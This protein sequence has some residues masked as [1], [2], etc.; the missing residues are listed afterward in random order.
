MAIE[1]TKPQRRI[2][3]AIRDAIAARGYPPTIREIATSLGRSGAGG[4]PA[5]LVVLERKGWIKRARC[6]SRA[7]ELVYQRDEH[8]DRALLAEAA[9]VAPI[10]AVRAALCALPEAKAVRDAA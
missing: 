9:R 6:T 3:D 8:A 7:I 5:A 1:L 2:L 4:V 10:E